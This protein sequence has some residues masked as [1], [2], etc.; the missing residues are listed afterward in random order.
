MLEPGSIANNTVTIR[1]GE[2]IGLIVLK[3]PINCALL[4]QP[5]RTISLVGQILIIKVFPFL[6]E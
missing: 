1:E 2:V 3:S 5:L 4:F 6:E